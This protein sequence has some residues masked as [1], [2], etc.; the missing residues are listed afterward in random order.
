[1]P[2]ARDKS[3]T[4]TN[5]EPEQ[6]V[7]DALRHVLAIENSVNAG[8]HRFLA[9]AAR[10]RGL[11]AQQAKHYRKA[12][13]LP[14]DI[15][16]R[17]LAGEAGG[18]SIAQMRKIARLS[19]AELQRQAFDALCSSPCPPSI[20]SARSHEAS[21]PEPCETKQVRCCIYFNPELFARQR[22][23]AQRTVR[24]I[25]TYVD[26]LNAGIRRAGCAMTEATIRSRIEHKLRKKE[27]LK[28]FSVHVDTIEQGGLRCL[29][30]RVELI[31]K[32]WQRRRRSDGFSV[33][34]AHESVSKSALE[35]CQAYRAKDAVERGF[36]TIKSAVELRPLRHRTAPKVR[37]HVTLCMLAL[38][39]HRTLATQ[40][41]DRL[42]Q[43]AHPELA[44]ESLESCQLNYF[45][46][47]RPVYSLTQP[48]SEQK[49]ILRA[50]RLPHLVEQEDVRAHL[51]PRG[52]VV[53]TR[54][55]KS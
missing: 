54:G 25:E 4:C 51:T 38:L 49:R 7:R 9:H 10:A 18:R 35:L 23:L 43:D 50:L 47:V 12:L 13:R 36:R 22:M 32:N 14:E 5:D 15:R 27:L 33:L 31:E 53:P 55:E 48:D 21:S 44:L 41:N 24:S 52:P 40:L 46:G 34:V 2:H 20:P 26:E 19:N 37:A 28:A 11:S 1:M 17:I 42:T 39:V 29:Q 8:S 45:A 16:Q 3:C 30:A 6:R